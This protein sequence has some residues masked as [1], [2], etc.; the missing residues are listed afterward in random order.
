MAK[1]TGKNAMVEID[2]EGTSVQ[3]MELRE[4]S[5]SVSTEKID[6][7][8]VGTEWTD[9]IDGLKSWEGEATCI[10]ADQYWLEFLGKRP[11]IKFY[12]HEGQEEPT[13]K[14]RASID[15]ERSVSYD[16][17]IESTLTFTGAGPLE[18]PNES[19]ASDGGG[20]TGE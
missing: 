19:G 6:A 2:V 20:T 7:S 9:S 12:D 8:A 16:D 10:S 17:V 15:V 1:M 5:V 14:G 4:W 11:L 18:Q 13:Y 3:V